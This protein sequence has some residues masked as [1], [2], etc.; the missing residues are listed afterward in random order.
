[1]D[2]DLVEFR[3]LQEVEIFSYLCYSLAKSLKMARNIPRLDLAVISV[4]KALN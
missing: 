3:Q 2:T 1:M 4:S